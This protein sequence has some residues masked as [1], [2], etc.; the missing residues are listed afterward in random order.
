MPSIRVSAGI[1]MYLGENRLC[2]DM[3]IPKYAP[4]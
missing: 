2:T 1:D 3:T 4:L